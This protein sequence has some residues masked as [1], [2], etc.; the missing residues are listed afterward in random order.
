MF[1][2][3]IMKDIP[4]RQAVGSLLLALVTRSYISYALRQVA[5][6]NT[7]PGPVNWNAVSRIFR[8][9]VNL[10]RW[11]LCINILRLMLLS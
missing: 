5:K 10:P 1:M 7:N 9:K 8:S 11:V 2:K 6:L 4:Y 3:D